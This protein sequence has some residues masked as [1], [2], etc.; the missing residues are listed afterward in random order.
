[1]FLKNGS[2]YKGIGA[3]HK[4]K[5]SFQY[6]LILFEIFLIWHIK[7]KSLCFLF[8]WAPHHEGVLGS[9]GIAPRIL[10][11]GTRWR[12]SAS[13]PSC[14]TPRERARGTQWIGG[15]V[16]LKA[17]LDT[18]VKKKNPSLF[19]DSNPRS[20]SA[21]LLSYPGSILYDIYLTK[22]NILLL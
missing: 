14:F 7:V 9:G 13:R 11:L 20:S 16:G 22:M 6:L 12:W 19:K 10:D 2:L 3:Q 1:M 17:G 21:I 4:I 8:N 15:W 18:V 5:N